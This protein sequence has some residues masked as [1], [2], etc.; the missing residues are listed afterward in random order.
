MEMQQQRNKIFDLWFM[1]VA[2]AQ[3]QAV[4]LRKT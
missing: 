4:M 2:T 1:Q 3:G